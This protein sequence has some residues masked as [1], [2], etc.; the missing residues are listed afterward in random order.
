ME[1]APGWW[2]GSFYTCQCLN[3]TSWINTWLGLLFFHF[4]LRK[5]ILS[6]PVW[7]RSWCSLGEH[8]RGRAEG[9]EWEEIVWDNGLGVIIPGSTPWNRDK[10][11]EV[12]TVLQS[13]MWEDGFQKGE[14]CGVLGVGSACPTAEAPS[15]HPT[16]PQTVNPPPHGIY[17]KGRSLNP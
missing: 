7:A 17:N 16:F 11:L 4:C 14:S 15:H 9:T 5:S 1:L 12:S 2:L 10:T 8:L 3:S 6:V 13:W